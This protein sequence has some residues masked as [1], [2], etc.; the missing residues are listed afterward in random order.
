[1]TE[2]YI[3]VC[4]LTASC[5]VSNCYDSLLL[6]NLVGIVSFIGVW[7]VMIRTVGVGNTSV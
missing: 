4:V 2:S 3:H 5:N 6:K 7:L 1:M